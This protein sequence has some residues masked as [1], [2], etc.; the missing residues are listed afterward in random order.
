MNTIDPVLGIDRWMDEWRE[1]WKKKGD[2]EEGRTLNS[3][4][5]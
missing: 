4:R 2:R 5:T 1:E 3:D